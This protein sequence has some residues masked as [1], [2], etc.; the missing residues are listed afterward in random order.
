MEQSGTKSFIF[1]IFVM[2]FLLA[3][4]ATPAHA[5]WA[6]T[7]GGTGNDHTV[8]FQQT[9]DEGY[10][11]AGSTLS[12]GAGNG[13]VWIMKLDEN[14]VVTWQKAYGTPGSDYPYSVRQTQDGDILWWVIPPLVQATVTPGS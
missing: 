7:Y 11:V 5:Q 12:F 10:I 9:L 6:Y 8:L 2:V 3:I 14:G 4:V 1:G 13:D